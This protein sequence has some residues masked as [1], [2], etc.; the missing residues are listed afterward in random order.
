MNG[1]LTV[2]IFRSLELVQAS[3][4]EAKDRSAFG[5]L[6]EI[7]DLLED[8]VPDLHRA[9]KKNSQMCKDTLLMLLKLS[10]RPEGLQQSELVM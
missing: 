5:T 8:L 9:V 4:G 10:G 1:S 6:Q 3:C 7:A 2:F